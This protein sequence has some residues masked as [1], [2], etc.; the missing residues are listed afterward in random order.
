MY[1]FVY[2]GLSD[3]YKVMVNSVS[4]AQH[5]NNLALTLLM[6]LIG[7]AIDVHSALPSDNVTVTAEFLHRGPY[8][9]ASCQ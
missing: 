7:F 1:Y 4:D 6:L 3:L 9:E 8:L 2:T 5:A